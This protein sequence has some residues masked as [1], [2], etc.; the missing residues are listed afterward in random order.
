MLGVGVRG[1]A[2]AC[3]MVMVPGGQGLRKNI[4]DGGEAV[5]GLLGMNMM[6]V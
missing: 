2:R 3:D 4:G 5:V 6:N 1:V